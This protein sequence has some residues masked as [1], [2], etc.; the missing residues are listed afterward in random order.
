M[1]MIRALSVLCLGLAACGLRTPLDELAAGGPGGQ[2]RS[3]PPFD[4]QPENQQSCASGD[5]LSCR[6]ES[7]LP[8]I[9]V[10]LTSLVYGE[11]TC[12]PEPLARIRDGILGDWFG[13]ATPPWADSYWVGFTFDS[14]DHYSARAAFAGFS[15]MYFGPDDESPNKRYT[16]DEIQD[17]G[18]ATGTIDI[19]YGFGETVRNKLEGLILSD[20][21]NQ[22]RFSFVHCG[23]YGPFQYDLQRVLP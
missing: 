3:G 21:L 10:C 9:R 8:G 2:R 13:T 6:C 1:T 23:Q 19:D 16:I 11:C 22:L 4:A 7:G 20:D 12:D 17:D 5:R 14:E 18:F 15:A